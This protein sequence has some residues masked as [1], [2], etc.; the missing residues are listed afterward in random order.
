ML[1][2]RYGVSGLRAGCPSGTA[3]QLHGGIVAIRQRSSGRWPV[4]LDRQQAQWPSGYEVG[5][6]VRGHVTGRHCRYWRIMSAPVGGSQRQ[7]RSWGH[8][9]R[10]ESLR[11]RAIP[12]CGGM[13]PRRALRR[14]WSC[15]PGPCDRS[16]GTW[17]GQ[18]NQR[19]V[20]RTLGPLAWWP[21]G[22]VCLPPSSRQW[23][24]WPCYLGG[25]FSVSQ[26]QRPSH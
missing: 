5:C 17:R 4:Q 13:G 18:G 26:R 15:C 8:F 2:S 16:T 6:P 12:P 7:V 23:L 20:S 19:Q 1:L 9:W 24:R 11:V 22:P 10:S 3:C 25:S 14:I 21:F